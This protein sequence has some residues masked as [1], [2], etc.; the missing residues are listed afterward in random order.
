MFDSLKTFFWDEEDA[1]FP[2]LESECH[3]S[4]LEIGVTLFEKQACSCEKLFKIILLV[5]WI[6][7]LTSVGVVWS[8]I[9]IQGV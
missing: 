3:F 6:C 1:L 2:N 7:I 4:Q 5:F 9:S 8:L